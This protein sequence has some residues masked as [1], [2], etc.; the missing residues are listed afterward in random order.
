MIT[1][2]PITMAEVQPEGLME[3]SRLEY[4]VAGAPGHQSQEVI[5]VRDDEGVLLYAGWWRGTLLGHKHLWVLLHERF[6]EHLVRNLRFL[7]RLATD[8]AEVWVENEVNARFAR[9]FGYEPVTWADG[10]TKMRKV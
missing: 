5:A 6:C 4:S 1:A 9:F 7:R 8:D 2:E 3:A 10:W